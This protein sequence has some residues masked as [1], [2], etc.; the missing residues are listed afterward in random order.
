MLTSSKP[1]SNQYLHFETH[2]IS[3]LLKDR[4]GNSERYRSLANIS[5]SHSQ[6]CACEVLVLQSR[7]QILDKQREVRWASSRVGSS[8]L[9]WAGQRGARWAEGD[10][11]KWREGDRRGLH[12]AVDEGHERRCREGREAQGNQSTGKRDWRWQQPD[13]TVYNHG[14]NY[15]LSLSEFIRET[16]IDDHNYN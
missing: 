8:T 12:S 5:L 10:D 2:I 4:L 15:D 13:A 9:L 14:G 1:L 7:V 11:G 6:S 3:T 16:T